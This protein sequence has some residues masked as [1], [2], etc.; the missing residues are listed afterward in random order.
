MVIILNINRHFKGE[1]L[2]HSLV[3]QRLRFHIFTTE[4]LESMPA[5]ETKIPQAVLH[6][7]KNLRMKGVKLKRKEVEKRR[8]LFLFG[9]FYADSS[10]GL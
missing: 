8:S 5:L 7:R 1:K 9:F 4:G 10:F 2:G 3:A 6:G